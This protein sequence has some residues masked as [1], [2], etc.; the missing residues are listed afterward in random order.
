[1]KSSIIMNAL[2]HLLFG[3][4][5][6]IILSLLTLLV[7]LYALAGFVLVPWAARPRIEEA[8]TILTGREAR[9]TELKLNPFTLSATLGG[10]ELTG[11]D[12][13]PLLSFSR[14]YANFQSLSYLFRGEYHFKELDLTDPYFRFQVN[15]DGSFNIGDILNQIS[16]ETGPDQEQEPEPDPKHLRVDVLKINNGSI[17]ITDLSRSAPFESVISPINFVIDGFHTSGEA[18]HPY[19]F[20][21][22]SES[23]E[24]ISWEGNFA[25]APFRS[26]G[27]FELTGFSLPKYEPFF[28]IVLL[29]D[30]VDGIMRMTGRYDYVSGEN[31]VIRLE[32]ASVAIKN[33]QVVKGSDQSPVLSLAD[34]SISGVT[35]D[36]LARTLE[37]QSLQFSDGALHAQR[38]QGGQ[39][40][41]HE[42][43]QPSLLEA[44]V[45]DTAADEEPKPSTLPAFKYQI[46]SVS[47]QDFSFN[48]LD[49]TTAVPAEL[50]L[51]V[52]SLL[53]ENIQ[54]EA[55]AQLNISLDSGLRSGGSIQVNGTAEIQPLGADLNI[56]IGGLALDAGN[57]YLLQIADL[58][59]A[60]GA[61][62]LTGHA[63]FSQENQLSEGGFSGDLQLSAL[64]V[65]DQNTGQDIA[66]LT[67]L[68]MNTIET[69]LEPMEVN[70][71]SIT[72]VEPRAT[73][74]ID[75]E[76]SINLKKAL[77][78]A[79]EE[80]EVVTEAET[81]TEVAEAAPAK[82]TGI[83][84]PFPV[85]IG[86]ITLE[87]AGA[88][89]TDRSVSP[90]VNLGLESLSGTIS[91]LS[92][93]TL[94]RADLDLSGTLVGGSQLAVSGKINPLIA[95][96]YSDV[97]MRFSDFNLTAVSP[98]SGKYAGYALDKGKLSFDLKYKI[99]QAELTGENVMVIDQLTLG[100]Q[101]D[102]E[103][104]LNL[105][106]PLAISLM[107]D[108]NV[109]IEIDIPVNGNLNDPEFGFG[110]VISRAIVNILTKLITSPF[111]MLG[112]LV[113]GGADIDLSQLTF[114]PASTELD[115]EAMKKLSLLA[116]ALIARPSLKLEIIGAAGG[117]AE[118]T[119]L[120]LMQLNEQL[121]TVRWREL[122]NAKKNAISLDEV[123][124]TQTERDRLVREEFAR[125]FPETAQA[126]KVAAGKT[127]EATQ[128][129]TP[130]QMESR[131]LETIE[132][133]QDELRQLATVRAEAVRS[134]LE[135]SDNI[136][137]DRLFI[138]EPTDPL[139]VDPDAGQP[140]AVFQ[141]N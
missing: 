80:A 1:M 114:T 14:A 58:Q 112:S 4:R 88:I 17:S 29:T 50:A 106:I 28:D 123:V 81:E 124:L 66:T 105:P 3:T 94:A 93:E 95:D 16:A 22:A 63:T 46:H 91:G 34:A 2:K 110:R 140:Q 71:G 55:G 127:T 37:V 85:S 83:V 132:I 116:D 48:L 111:S 43:L 117:S 62:D 87:G 74:L 119:Q 121:K 118:M 68:D 18:E 133:S 59:L 73:L 54:S 40:D 96:R 113:P 52:V 100:K 64:R 78:I 5:Y 109:V 134:H 136:T 57:P 65:I 139:L 102:S 38:F 49:Q 101:V 99:S 36:H 92:S 35:M 31:G 6:R 21:A 27:S 120:K 45:T 138:A 75:E 39:I 103:D 19:T 72:L 129:L 122:Q 141:L 130:A 77:R 47:L 131:L 42:L 9:L 44:D 70:I 108:S 76:G 98:Y 32:D 67:R 8:L 86:S 56:A 7:G 90:A 89:L 97:E 61:L 82:P 33:L 41:L 137:P 128:Q 12:A 125:T 107:K 79:P 10:F 135:T 20:S 53:L 11:T 84:L 26:K 126:S 15:A 30:I 104:A 24:S 51:E 60:G 115:Q 13:K 23:G 69:A 25:L